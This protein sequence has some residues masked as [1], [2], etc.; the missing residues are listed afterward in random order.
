MSIYIELRRKRTPLT[1]PYPV[2][3]T[4]AVILPPP[5]KK[6]ALELCSLGIVVLKEKEACLPSGL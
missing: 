1:R 2:T 5:L 3:H 6:L 4:S